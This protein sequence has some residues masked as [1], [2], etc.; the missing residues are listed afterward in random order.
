MRPSKE[1]WPLCGTNASRSSLIRSAV[2]SNLLARVAGLLKRV[3][4][5]SGISNPIV[6]RCLAP[7]SM[8]PATGELDWCDA[9]LCEDRPHCRWLFTLILLKTSAE[10]VL[11]ISPSLKLQSR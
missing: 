6:I 4:Y 2:L 10:R 5:G 3:R 1:G 9:A 8:P 11:N 7:R